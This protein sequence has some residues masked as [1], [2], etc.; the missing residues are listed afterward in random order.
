MGINV[1]LRQIHKRD[2]GSKD[3]FNGKPVIGVMP[4]WDETKESYWMLPGYMQGIREQGAIALMPQLED[5]PEQLDY[6]VESCDG[7]LLTGGQDVDPSIY[8]AQRTQRCQQP[9]VLRDRMDAYILT[10]AVQ[11]NKAVLGICRGIQLMNATYGGTLYQ[12]LPTEHPSCI[13]HSMSAPYDR[14]A[15]AVQVHPGTPLYA[16]W[17]T[18]QAP[19]NSCHHQ[20]ICALASAFA[21]MAE[22]PDGLIEAICMQDR[23]FVWGVQW[24]PEFSYL[25]D[26]HSRQ[27]FAA[28]VQAAKQN[29]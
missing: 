19:V 21:P 25:R 2:G 29:I 5:A 3:V 11:Q 18:D 15:H 24:H 20:G 26:I 8:G 27:I 6:F 10:H 9:V 28:F 4:L 17:R 12:D 23:S 14:G 16:L 1:P 13:G 22:A 7:F